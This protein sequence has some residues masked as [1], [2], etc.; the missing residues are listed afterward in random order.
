MFFNFILQENLAC[1][2]S[3]RIG[4]SLTLAITQKTVYLE[5]DRCS[6]NVHQR[7]YVTMVKTTIGLFCPIIVLAHG[8]IS[9]GE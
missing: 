8:K 7:N 6:R 9:N 1:K 2:I 5:R 3:T 4:Q